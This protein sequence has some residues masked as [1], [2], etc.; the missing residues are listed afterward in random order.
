MTGSRQCFLFRIEGRRYAVPLEAVDRVVHAVAV[1]PLSDGPEVVLG[2]INLQGRIVPVYDLRRRLGLP[3]RDIRLEDYL[4]VAHSGIRAVA[5]FADAVE[6]V[7]E[8]PEGAIS[9]G[10]DVVPGL[11]YVRGVMRLGEDLVLL[12][13]LQRVLSAEDEERLA[14]AMEEAITNG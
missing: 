14:E 6:G 3:A 10:S 1:T 13:D 4:V 2:V 5:F 7:I 11:E 8:E 9:E 12:H